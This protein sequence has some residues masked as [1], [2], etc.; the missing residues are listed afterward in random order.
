MILKNT[1]EFHKNFNERKCDKN[2]EL[3]AKNIHVCSNGAELTGRKAFVERIPQFTK[4]FPDVAIQDISSYTDGNT[5]IDHFAIIGTHKV[6]LPTTG[7]V[8]PAQNRKIKMEGGRFSPLIKT[9]K[10]PIW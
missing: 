5:T 6:D 3:V 10:L 9:V 2:R 4:Y 8:I 7:G 1:A